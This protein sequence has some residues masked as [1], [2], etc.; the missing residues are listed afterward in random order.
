MIVRLSDLTMPRPFSSAGPFQIYIGNLTEETTV[1]DI[2]PLF[3]KY[4]KVVECVVLQN[5]GFVHM[6]SEVAGRK[7]IQNLNGLLVNGQAI[8]CEV[9]RNFIGNLAESTKATQV[10]TLFKKYGHVVVCDII[11]NYGFVYLDTSGDVIGAIKELNGM[12]VDGEPMIV[13]RTS[14]VQQRPSILELMKCYRCRRR[15]WTLECP[16][17]A[18]LHLRDRMMGGS[19]VCDVALYVITSFTINYIFLKLLKGGFTDNFGWLVWF[20]S[21]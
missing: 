6:K 8:L 4:G 20:S 16:K 17:S 12:L 21:I 1:N 19:G 3:E 10:R 11:R 13:K 14:D 15:H 2:K 18:E 7:C 9:A 5:Y